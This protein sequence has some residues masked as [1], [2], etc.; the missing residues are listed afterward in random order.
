MPATTEEVDEDPATGPTT[1]VAETAADGGG[2]AAGEGAAP[3]GPWVL[4]LAFALALAPFVVSAIS[5]LVGHRHY[6][7]MGDVAVT[8]LL[9][10][11]VG[12]RWLELGPFSRDGWFHPGPAL[13][14]VLAGPYRLFG[15]TTAA[16][17]VGAL[18][19]N[20]A[21]VA[22]MGLIARRRGGP[23]LGL[24]TLLGCALLVRSL[25]PD[26][27]RVPWNPWVTVLPYGLL[28]F[29]TVAMACRDRWALPLAVGVA[30]FLAQTHIGF[31][32]LAL[33]L[34]A[35]GAVWLVAS[36]PEGGRRRLIVPGLVAAGV[37]AL[38]WL[39]P[40]VQQLTNHPGNLTVA[41]RWFHTGGPQ[42]YGKHPLSIGWRLVSSQYFIA[43][44]WL[45]G[46]RGHANTQE[47]LALYRPLA[48]G[49]LLLV[50]VA[51]IVLW[52]RRA[53]GAR[54]LLVVWLAA[55]LISIVA[56]AR[57]LGPIYAYRTGWTWVLGM[58]GGVIIA[59]ALWRALAALRPSLQR[60]VLAPVALV[61]LAAVSLV[62]A[63]AHVDGGLP[64]PVVSRKMAAII[65]Q[66]EAGLPDRPGQIIVTSN[67]FEGAGY[68]GGL[69]LALERAGY[70]ARVP[71]GDKTA[72]PARAADG[73][74]VRATLVVSSDLVIADSSA[75][76]SLRRIAYAGKI[77]FAELM[78]R[79]PATRAMD[80]Y[81]ATGDT[82]VFERYGPKPK[83]IE[84]LSTVA[85]FVQRDAGSP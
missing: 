40:A 61:A 83:V 16:M 39:P 5:L 53:P 52:R 82:T 26:L 38:M 81:F 70:D 41:N 23:V 21:S 36:P 15:S 22:G 74:A 67:S 50:G 35:L 20:G 12:R 49:L 4:R 57:T 17:D 28:V 72:G 59:W 10:R 2:E 79:A 9:T 45:F 48:P 80:A 71:A 7:A 76:R 78:A 60:T 11:D 33:P 85:V 3:F 25:G 51:A 56:T 65:P 24:L 63:V 84:Q 42:H 19:V 8:E 66:V 46:A 69:L 14:Y 6:P 54:P 32:P 64:N 47:P 31:V 44:E 68:A 77:P 37:A 58:V 55:S 75:D 1:E 62:T 18:I 27:T 29:L 73:G 34:V 43:P 30:S 13:F